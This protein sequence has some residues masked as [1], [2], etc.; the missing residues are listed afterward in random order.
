MDGTTHPKDLYA[1]TIPRK[2]EQKDFR[3]ILDSK[4][5]IPNMTL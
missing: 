2:W 4:L 1:L 3:P 5:K